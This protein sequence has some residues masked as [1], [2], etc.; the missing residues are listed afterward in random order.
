MIEFIVAHVDDKPGWGLDTKGYTIG[1][2]MADMEEFHLERSNIDY[3]IC[4]Y[5]IQLCFAELAA[6]GKFYFQ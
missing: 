1:Y 4:L 2:G 6:T 5:S 3:I